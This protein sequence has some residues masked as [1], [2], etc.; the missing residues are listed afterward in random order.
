MVGMERQE[1]WILGVIATSLLFSALELGFSLGDGVSG[2]YSLWMAPVAAGLT[3]I[4]HLITLPLW[5]QTA[6]KRKSA[7]P[8]V[9]PSIYSVT[10]CT[11]SCL[12]AILWLAS[13]LTS[14]V[15][16]SIYAKYYQDHATAF[17]WLEAVFALVNMGLMWAEFGLVVHYRRQFFKRFQVMFEFPHQEKFQSKQQPFQG[18]VTTTKAANKTKTATATEFKM[19]TKLILG[20]I[21]V[22][23][24]L[25][26]AELGIL[27]GGG[28]MG[29]Y[30]LWMGPFI[31]GVTI[32]LHLVTLP[33]WKHT[34][35]A[36]KWTS[37]PP[38]ICSITLSVLTCLL[39][40]C[41]L[42]PAITTILFASLSAT[43]SDTNL[44]Y[45]YDDRK[46][47]FPWIEIALSFIL[48]GLMWFELVLIL[49]SRVRFLKQSKR[50]WY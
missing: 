5:R 19:P 39:A 14:F 37:K 22:S 17:S 3:L 47:V 24:V 6:K 21:L 2:L 11:L 18:Q 8:T 46:H 38:F 10:V 15:F 4:F 25:S 29:G 7:A 26:I 45:E 28:A 9:P 23:L 13:T 32:I 12:L 30:S 16:V 1:K 50:G 20:T 27:L 48:S 44:Y 42:A 43:D 31:A 33:V 36:R 41:W 35:E 49:R 34:A 40:V